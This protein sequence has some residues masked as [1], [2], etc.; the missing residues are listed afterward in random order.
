MRLR[1]R[2]RRSRRRRARRNPRPR[3][4]D[5]LAKARALGG[6]AAAKVPGLRRVPRWGWWAL[7][8]GGVLG[9]VWFFFF[10]GRTHSIDFLKQADAAWSK[11]LLG[12]SSSDTIGEAGCFLTA[13]VMAVNSFT[14]DTLTPDVAQSAAL[15][16]DKTSFS[17]ANLNLAVAADSLGIY[18]PESERVHDGGSADDI[19]AAIDHALSHRGM[20]IIH[21]A[22]DFSTQG[23]HF[24]L[25]YGKSSGQYLVAD[26]APGDSVI[27]DPDSLTGTS[28]WG[29]KTYN[30]KVVGAAPVY[31]SA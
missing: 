22:M 19:R 13:L 21:V 4:R 30:Y 11:T 10:R 3:L 28:D 25:V 20:A 15:S 17:G 29:Y 2:A 31:A 16:V 12:T 27:I 6:R 8:A 5:I 14:K 26:P 7:G 1:T 9:A 23:E 18:A 24:L